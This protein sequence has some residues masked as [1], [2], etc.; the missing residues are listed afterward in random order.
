MPEG[1]QIEKWETDPPHSEPE[2]SGLKTV[3]GAE[4]SNLTKITFVPL[5]H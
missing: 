4:T 3:V 1:I 5:L 2:G